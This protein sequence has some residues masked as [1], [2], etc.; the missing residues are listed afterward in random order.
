MPIGGS[1]RMIGL[2]ELAEFLGIPIETVRK[3]WRGWGLPGVRIGK[4]IKFRERDVAAWL[5]GLPPA[6]RRGLTP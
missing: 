3:R 2:E 5:D 6:L 1:N 4:Y